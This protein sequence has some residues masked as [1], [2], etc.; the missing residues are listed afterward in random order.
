[1]TEE[2]KV[3]KEKP[4]TNSNGEPF[5]V[6]LN[7]RT[8]DYIQ[9]HH[10][11]RDL[12]KKG[13]ELDVDYKIEP[14]QHLKRGKL[15][16]L[17]VIATKSIIDATIQVTSQEGIRGNAQ[18][19]SYY[20]SD[21]KKKGAS[22]ELRKLSGYEYDQVVVSKAMVTNFLDKFIAGEGRDVKFKVNTNNIDSEDT[23]YSCDLCNY[24]TR[25]QAG[26]KT[27]K[28]RIHK[29]IKCGL[30]EFSSVD[31][32]KLKEHIE[33]EHD[34]K[35]EGKKRLVNIIQCDLC[36]ST[37]DS[38]EKQEEPAQNQHVKSDEKL[39]KEESE[40]SPTSSPSRKKLEL[41]DVENKQEDADDDNHMDG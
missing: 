13:V 27:H 20:P 18:L 1:M 24:K 21:S 19:K 12:I 29:T 17:N 15:K 26:V 23:V 32:N 9:A 41:A 40:K 22:T 5:G 31:E 28:T 37:F 33:T 11:F 16:F 36:G 8:K 7:G 35:D 6:T 34:K 4:Y 3:Y 25:S 10:K 2:F 14:N 30:C 38:R 39:K